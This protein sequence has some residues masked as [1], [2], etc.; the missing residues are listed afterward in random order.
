M[1]SFM[2][3]A[4]MESRLA[5]VAQQQQSSSALQLPAVVAWCCVFLLSA[6]AI[7]EVK[8]PEPMPLG[9]PQNE[10]S[11]ERALA[12]VRSLAKVPHP[13]GT[14]A[15]A[16][17]RQY[18]IG[19]LF[20]LG[21]NPQISTAVGIYNGPGA[22]IAGRTNDIVGRLSGT[23]NSGAILLMAHYDSVSSGPGA[24]DDASGVAAIL[25]GVR[26]LKTGPPLK[27]DLIVL[28]TDGEEAGLLGAE[29]FVASHPWMKDVGLLMNFEARGTHG[30]SLLFE[31]SANNA[32]LM[33]EVGK[34]TPYP[35]ASS[36]FY[37]LYKLLPNDTDF[38]RFRSARIPGL[39]F[40]FG[41]HLEGYHS[42]MDTPENLDITSLQHQGSYLLSLVRHFGQMNLGNLKRESGDDIFF[43][44]FGA[45]LIT[46]SERWVLIGQIGVTLLLALIIVFSV[47]RKEVGPGR[48]F[49]AM[50]V[51]LL[52]LLVVPGIM[53]I[54]G[55]L[56]LLILSGRMLLGDTPANF[57]L[58]NG[59][60]LL[61]V[62][63]G[64]VVL[65]HFRRRFHLQELLLAGLTVVC[66]LS[67]ALTLLLPAG[68][69]LLFWPLFSAV[70]GF[71]V[72]TI[73]RAGSPKVQALA[74][75]PG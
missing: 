62:V 46:Y 3:T 75:L 25:E 63:T 64:S 19:Q 28:I 57:F 5:S 35:I 70:C 23:S 20:A 26:A 7:F 32:V 13:A 11:A 24:A 71:P 27:N 39:N 6:L 48:F 53:A 54:A 51:S 49:G 66:I 65:S 8:A 16:E 56:L 17:A 31:T 37:S 38:T 9:A 44:W 73:L 30:P 61:G 69:Y 55:W 41:G 68:N 29:A 60:V 1:A 10:F 42:S 4:Q 43:D 22:V 33:N 74:A 21:M 36:L 18:L 72:L 15:N 47:Q 59:L 52:V 12:H 40:A 58:L 2:H 45:N 67:W 14:N 50:A 34:S